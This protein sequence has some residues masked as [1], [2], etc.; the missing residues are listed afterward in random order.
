MRAKR[1][2]V[3][4]PFAVLTAFV[5]FGS[6][7]AGVGHHSS[8]VPVPA[9]HVSLLPEYAP[10]PTTE[11]PVQPVTVSPGKSAPARYLLLP[12]R[13]GPAETGPLSW[14]RGRRAR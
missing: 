9:P 2:V 7:A 3:F 8:P 14:P 1:A 11:L 10:V 5:T 6:V 12:G 4:I 13:L